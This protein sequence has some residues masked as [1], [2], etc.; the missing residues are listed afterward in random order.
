[1]N[2][3]ANLARI[4]TSRSLASLP[5]L[6]LRSK[7][8]NKENQLVTALTSS[9]EVTQLQVVKALY[10]KS[11]AANVRALQKLQSRVRSK[12]LNQLYFLDHSD[13]RHLVSRR[14]ELECLDLLHKVS[15]LYAEREY[16]LTERLLQRCLRMSQQGEFTQYEVQ[17]IR[18][19]RSL[20]AERQQVIP[21]KKATKALQKAQQLLA[22]E[23][24]AEQLYADTQLALNGSVVARRAV[25]AVMPERIAQLELLH[26]RARSFTTY[27]MV[28]RARLAYE[29]L[30]GNFEEMIRVTSA[31][32]KRWQQGKLN[33]RRFDLRFN[34]FVSIFAY[35]RSRQPVQGLRLAEEYT[36]DFHPSSS[37]WF[38]FQEHHVLLAL[39]AEEYERAQQLMAIIMKNP[40]YIIQREAAL[41][42]WDLYR[43]YIDFVLPAPRASTVRQRQL[44][45]LVLQLPDYSRDKR[46]HNVAILV[47]QLLYFL[48]ERNLEA[49]LMRLERLRKYQQR[50]LYEAATIRSR[51]FL[52]LLQLTVE[53]NFDASQAAERGKALLEQ[54]RDTPPPGNAFAEVE[55][56]PYEHL[57]ELVLGLLRQ[58]PPVPIEVIAQ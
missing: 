22:W 24:E 56:I 47:L 18:M 37:N 1:M 43:A 55:I 50:H 44:A 48:R 53:K 46:G 17:C 36:R 11:T 20:H 33:A 16:K 28:Y 2:E 54:L 15:I 4:V 57:W 19:L 8:V 3:I 7:Q 23:D 41:Q 13:A 40:A 39:H 52:R 45:Q 29:E 26:K 49:V 10:G 32:A 27:N 34:H 21:F 12:L 35:L 30:Q 25:L 58:G 38:Y 31:A 14:Y 5:V 9:P 6:D 42:R 51:L